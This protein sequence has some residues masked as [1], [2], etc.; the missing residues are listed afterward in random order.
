MS[1]TENRIQNILLEE[2]ENFE[3]ILIATTNLAT[4]MDTAFER[5]FLFKVEFK[6]PSITAKSQI[7]KSKMPHLSND[8]CKLLASQF[9]F[10]GGQIDNVVRKNE[11]NEII[12]GSK[13]DVKTLVE[14][15]KEEILSN[16]FS[17]TKIGFNRN[18]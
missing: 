10:S 2:I 16:Q 1:D 8:D 15:C 12:Y 4:N 5:R 18:N 9:D 11:I 17:G 14:F 3:G 6:K 13:V 7:W